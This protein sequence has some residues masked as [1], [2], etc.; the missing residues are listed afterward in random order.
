[1]FEANQ[2]EEACE[3]F[4]KVLSLQPDHADALLFWGRALDELKRYEEALEKFIHA[5]IVSLRA[6][7]HLILIFG[8][9]IATRKCLTV[10]CK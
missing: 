8:C 5:L 1:M 9:I 6:L 2:F 3:E 7:H 10:E 4:K